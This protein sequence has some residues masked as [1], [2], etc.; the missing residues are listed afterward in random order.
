MYM[1]YRPWQYVMLYK[2]YNKNNMIYGYVS[3]IINTIIIHMCNIEQCF[4]EPNGTLAGWQQPIV[5]QYPISVIVQ[6]VT[7]S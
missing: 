1:P 3:I 7:V 5:Q 4:Y 6:Y 2:R